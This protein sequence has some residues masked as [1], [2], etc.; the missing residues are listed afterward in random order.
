MHHVP[1]QRPHRLVVG[2]TTRLGK[3]GAGLVATIVVLA[4]AVVTVVRED[5]LAA[6]VISFAGS[7]LVVVAGAVLFAAIFR[8]TERALSVYAA[9]LMLVGG[10]LFLLFHSLFISD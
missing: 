2:P 8:R 3:W 6:W 9:A 4:V 10:V 5:S 1:A 7:A